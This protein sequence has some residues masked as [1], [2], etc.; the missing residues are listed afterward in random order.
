VTA[1]ARQYPA[2][3]LI[4][5]L[6]DKHDQGGLSDAGLTIITARDNRAR[7]WTAV[8]T[9]AGRDSVILPNGSIVDAVAEP[10]SE[11][12]ALVTFLTESV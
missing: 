10:G 4:F 3:T 6:L 12:E 8:M 5:E 11:V 2:H 1:A 7:T 9:A